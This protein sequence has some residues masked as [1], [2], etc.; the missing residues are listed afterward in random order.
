MAAMLVPE[1]EAF[2]ISFSYLYHQHNRC[3][4][5]LQGMIAIVIIIILPH[6]YCYVIILQLFKGK[7]FYC[8]GDSHVVN[9]T[10]CL[11]STR[12]RWVNRRYNFDNLL[13]VCSAL[14]TYYSFMHSFIPCHLFVSLCQ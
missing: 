11:N 14:T 13:Q 10:Q 1:Y 9:R 6:H 7:L 4:L 2:L 8:E 3:T 12:G 5:I